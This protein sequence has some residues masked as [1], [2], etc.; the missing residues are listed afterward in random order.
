MQARLPLQIAEFAGKADALRVLDV[1]AGLGGFSAAFRDRG[2]D[3]RTLDYDAAF[4]CTYTMDLHEFVRDPVAVLGHWRPDIILNGTDCTGFCTPSIGKMWVKDTH[5]PVPKHETAQR[6]LGLLK[7]GMVVVEKLKPRWWVFENPTGKMRVVMRDI[8]G[9]EPLGR[10]TPKAPSTTYCRYGESYRKPE[11]LW[12]ILPATFV[13]RPP[14]NGHPRNGF[15]V[16]D[17]VSWT[18]LPEG[19]S[20]SVRKGAIWLVYKDG[21]EEK[22]TKRVHVLTNDGEPCHEAASRGAKTGVQGLKDSARRALVPYELSL[23]L[24]EAIEN[25]VSTP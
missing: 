7:V 18:Y 3:V 14:C 10:I 23:S 1:C 25:A 2:H 13:P 9:L 8:Y 22:A 15:A 21:R 16:R 11:D 20:V 19:T 4:K 24:C 12:G 17:G 6:C 5:P